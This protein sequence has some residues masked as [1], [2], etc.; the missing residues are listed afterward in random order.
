MTSIK[1]RIAPFAALALCT[2]QSVALAAASSYPD[3][4]SLASKP[5][6]DTAQGAAVYPS[7]PVRFIVPFPPGASDVVARIVGQK[8]SEQTGQQFVIDNRSGAASTMGAAIAAKAPADG[9]TIFFTTASFAISAGYYRNLPYD[10]ARDFAAVGLIA[11]GPL[12]MVTNTATPAN[13]ARE[14]IALAKA[15]PD[16]LNF[17][18][19]GAGSVSHLAAERFKTMAGIRITHVPYRGAGPALTDLLAGQVQLMFAPL[20]V[21]LPLVKS[22]KLKALGVP[23]EQ[24]SALAP[25]LP[26]IA[27]SGIPGYAAATWYGVLA[28]RGTP[29][30]VIGRLN[31]Q[32]VTVLKSAGMRDQLATLGIEPSPSTAKE[33]DVYL[34]S[35]IVKWTKT[36]RDANINP[37]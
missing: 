7:R 30:N 14:F 32:M 33:F 35:E 11:S 13:S 10:T 29:D 3:T 17:A 12:L 15:K 18:S 23:G 6:T 22:G 25:D 9:Y 16:A 5:R 8:L 19:A 28:P 36:I 26:T 21:L 4:A 34:Q 24:R 20:G 37:E 1:R 27:E 31:A 2:V